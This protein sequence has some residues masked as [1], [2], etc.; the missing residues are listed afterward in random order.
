MRY[1]LEGSQPCFRANTTREWTLDVIRKLDLDPSEI[2]TLKVA[3]A[4]SVWR[5]SRGAAA[6]ARV[7]PGP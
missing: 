5:P 3:V 4:L 7:P 2:L 6:G 1:E